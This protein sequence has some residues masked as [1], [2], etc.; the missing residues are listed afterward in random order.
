MNMNSNFQTTNGFLAWLFVFAALANSGYAETTRPNVVLI[1]ADDHGFPDYGFMGSQTV[2]TPNIDRLASQSSLYT[3][4]YTMPLCSPSLACLLTGLLPH[5]N[6]ITGND[7]TAPSGKERSDKARPGRDPLA[8][9]LLSNPIIL[10]K[11][12]TDAGYLTFQ[13]GKLWNTTYQDVGFTH[14]MTDTAGRHGDA[15][16][17]IGRKGMKP[18]FDFIDLAM[19][20]KQPFF[21]WYAPMM[22]HTPH[23]PPAELLEKYQGKGPT[24]AAEKYFAMVEWFDQTVGQLDQYLADH[25]QLENTVFLYLADNGWDGIHGHNSARAKLSPYEMGIRTP[26]FVRWP[27]KVKPDRDDQTLASVIDF[28]PTILKATGLPVPKELSGIDLCDSAAM[29]K[30]S[31]VFVEAYTHDIADLSEP[32]KSL[33]AQV[34]IQGSWKLLVPGNTK[35]DKKFSSAPDKY[36]LFDLSSDPL[37]ASDLASAHPQKVDEL[38]TIQRA[39][40]K[41]N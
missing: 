25:Q 19:K 16:L 1:I 8:K 14:G 34:V 33:I 6:G 24:P 13:S 36:E 3:R 17:D 30:R 38:L 11:A 10:P 32:A 5:Q 2:R 27:G 37:E 35:S 18:M 21:I 31:A 20:D 15:G 9:Q 23:N 26:M 41:V 7:L 12:L 4:G 39:F 40:W 29:Q 22:P 28:V